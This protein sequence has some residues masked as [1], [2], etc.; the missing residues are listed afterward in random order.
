MPAIKT[1]TV[2]G[3]IFTMNSINSQP[4]I[5]AISKFWGS[6]TIVQTPPKAVPTTPCII[7]SLRKALK[8]SKS[9]IPTSDR[10]VL[11]WKSCS[12]TENSSPELAKW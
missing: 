5:F 10:D 1:G 3:A 4:A 8:L 7:R 6:P 11:S 2:I 12:V 9:S